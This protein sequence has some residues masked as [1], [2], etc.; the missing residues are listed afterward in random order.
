MVLSAFGV[1]APNTD[2]RA[3]VDAVDKDSDSKRGSSW[4]ALSSAARKRG[5]WA[6]GL[7]R[8]WKIEDI[9]NSVLPL[10]AL[11][12]YQLLPDHFSSQSTSDHYIVLLAVDSQGNVL[13]HDPW[14]NGAYRMMTRAQLE[15]AWSNATPPWTG[16]YLSTR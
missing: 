11:T 15:Q 7:S 16:M 6:T 14:R 13:Y 12:R 1:A 10:I 4:W 8:R 9:S 2:L 5:V 3:D